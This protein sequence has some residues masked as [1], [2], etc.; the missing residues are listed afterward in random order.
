[1][2]TYPFPWHV[3]WDNSPLAE[4]LSTRALRHLRNA[5]RRMSRRNYRQSVK[6]VGV[7]Q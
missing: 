6:A 2:R 5:G 4:G 7:A 3:C 1:M